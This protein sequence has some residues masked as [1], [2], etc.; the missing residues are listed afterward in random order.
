MYNYA[1]RWWFF[2]SRLWRHNCIILRIRLISLLLSNHYIRLGCNPAKGRP[3]DH[4]SSFAKR[5]FASMTNGIHFQM[6]VKS[7]CLN[8]MYHY[9]CQERTPNSRWC[10]QVLPGL[11][12]MLPVT[13]KAG[14]KALL[15]S[16]TLLK[17]THL[18]LHSS[19]SQT[20]LEAFSD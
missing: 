7:S 1:H 16:D 20:L 4:M 5:C 6:V 9:R 19:S 15:G 12:P 14:R 10:T 13:L 17:L 3:T 11:S 18:S 8:N 2:T